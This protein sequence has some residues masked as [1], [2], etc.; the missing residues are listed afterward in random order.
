MAGKLFGLFCLLSAV[1]ACLT[2]RGEAFSAAVLNGASQTVTLML[3][4][5]GSM[6]LWCGLLE[7]LREAGAIHHLQKL[8]YPLL[9]RLFPSAAEH[10]AGLD[11]ISASIAANLLG[12]GNAATPLGLA[13]M[14]KLNEDGDRL[15]DDQALFI[16][17]NT[18][19]PALL[20]TTLLTLR[21]TA[22]S[23]SPFAVLPFV[24]IVSLSG[25]VFAVIITKAL[26]GCFDTR[27]R[28]IAAPHHA[29]KQVSL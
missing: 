10:G 8:L 7:V 6:C 16:V 26:A 25:T 3:A 9:R 17:L 29:R 4:L 1:C 21:H 19:P 5:G 22:G 23:V 20:P 18:A 11:E 2:G 12:I 13:A 15:T 14:E 24:W 27:H 28:K